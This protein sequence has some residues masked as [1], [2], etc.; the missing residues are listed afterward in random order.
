[1]F[2]LKAKDTGN[3]NTL[4]RR[5]KPEIRKKTGCL[6]CFIDWNLLF[7]VS[8]FYLALGG[9]KVTTFLTSIRMHNLFNLRTDILSSCSYSA[10]SF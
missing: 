5:R 10:N 1:M 6:V 2:Q 3:K 4:R 7:F 9:S 8:L